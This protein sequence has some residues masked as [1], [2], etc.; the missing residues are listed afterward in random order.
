M[1]SLNYEQAPPVKFIILKARNLNSINSRYI[2]VNFIPTTNT[3]VYSGIGVGVFVILFI[4][5]VIIT[6][7]CKTKESDI[8][9]HFMK[10]EIEE[11]F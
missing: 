1:I 11:D 7:R 9:V 5:L 4:L 2:R 6:N 3:L 8:E 10:E